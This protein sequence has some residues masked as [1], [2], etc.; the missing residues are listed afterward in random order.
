MA[1]ARARDVENDER[2]ARRQVTADRQATVNRIARSVAAW[3]SVNA[4][5]HY[6]EEVAAEEAGGASPFLRTKNETGRETQTEKW[7]DDATARRETRTKKWAYYARV[8]T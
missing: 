4:Q 2:D 7:D 1:N 5:R 6:A 8:T 3:E